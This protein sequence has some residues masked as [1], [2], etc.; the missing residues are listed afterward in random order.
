MV[1][2]LVLLSSIVFGINCH[3]SPAQC[4]SDLVIANPQTV[5]NITQQCNS[6]NIDDDNVSLNP[7]SWLALLV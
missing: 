5:A 7:A 2:A 1:V 3:E 4:L 6:D